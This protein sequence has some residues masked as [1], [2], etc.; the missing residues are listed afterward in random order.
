M[1]T[2]K[3]MLRAAAAVVLLAALAPLA[4]GQS[5]SGPRRGGSASR[6]GGAEAMR[7]EG[8]PESELEREMMYREME[9]MGKRKPAVRREQRLP[10][11]QL[12]EDFTRIQVVNNELVVAAGRSEPL[13]L[14]FVA[15]SASEIRKLA[16]RLRDNLALP[17][18]DKAHKPTMEDIT[19]TDQL[20]SSL[21][22][23]GKLIAGFAHNPV[24]KETNV[25]D[26]QLSA[27]ARRDI[28]EIIELSGQIK[29][30]SEKLNKAAQKP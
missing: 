10:F 12:S 20:R 8:T 14:K 23:L 26:A 1:S 19:E 15:K 4:Q 6:G 29:K 11:A 27:K 24:F 30:S 9:E 16:E 28:E 18:L 5:G 25:V 2:S 3:L 17:E 13:D 7:R 21:S 22:T